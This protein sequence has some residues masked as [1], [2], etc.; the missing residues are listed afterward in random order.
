MMSAGQSA[1][2][3]LQPFS[4]FV[5]AK[6]KRKG[7]SQLAATVGVKLRNRNVQPPH[8]PNEVFSCLSRLE[9]PLE[10]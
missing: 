9:N 6:R 8:W 3:I 7:G 5:S 4:L 10:I 1:G 2:N